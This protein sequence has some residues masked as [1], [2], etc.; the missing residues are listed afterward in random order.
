MDGL[1][2]I[3]FE[4]DGETVTGGRPGEI[5]LAIYRVPSELAETEITEAEAEQY[6]PPRF[7]QAKG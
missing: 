4:V 1:M 2:E 7:E 5:W 3:H 6:G